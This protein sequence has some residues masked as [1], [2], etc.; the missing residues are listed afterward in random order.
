M[1]GLSNSK[2]VLR[3]SAIAS[4]LVITALVSGCSSDNDIATAQF[5]VTV[6]NLSN[7]QPM[8]P[9]AVV[10]HNDQFRSFTLGE[11]AS[12]PIETLAEGGDNSAY[13]TEA[14]NDTNVFA[15]ASG[16]GLLM[17]GASETLDLNVNLAYLGTLSLSAVSMFV[18]TN[19]AIVALN[20]KSI[21]DMSV[22]AVQSFNAITYDSGTEANSETADSIPGP[23]ASGGAAEGF[24]AARDDVRDAVFVHAGVIT[25]D[26]GLSTSVLT[27]A[28]RWDNP[29]VRI[30]VE[31]VR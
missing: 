28:H 1:F 10:A 22:D 23:A 26:D 5:E 16:A 4:P 9:V 14:N 29:S 3:R 19:D 2:K 6:T 15:T 13:I 7:A 30:V 11:P 20:S 18:N 21:S 8:S 17:P 31:R 27:H 25:Q 12:V 24:N